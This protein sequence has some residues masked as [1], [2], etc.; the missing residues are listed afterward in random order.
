VA[1][2]GSLNIADY[3]TITAFRAESRPPHA[4]THDLSI[5]DRRGLGKLSLRLSPLLTAAQEAL[6]AA[7]WLLTAG[8]HRR[9][10]A[11]LLPGEA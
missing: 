10:R 6:I 7:D 8:Y 2:L 1:N 5:V 11:G 3:S 9:H 4:T